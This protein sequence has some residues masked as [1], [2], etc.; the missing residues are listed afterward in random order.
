MG[1]GLAGGAVVVGGADA[2]SAGWVALLAG[3]VG[4]V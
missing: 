2:G 3:V 1:D 4:C